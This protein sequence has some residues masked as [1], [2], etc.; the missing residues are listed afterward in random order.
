MHIS[1][2]VKKI[3]LGKRSGIYGYYSGSLRARC[4]KYVAWLEIP[5]TIIVAVQYLKSSNYRIHNNIKRVQTK[6]ML[7]PKNLIQ[8]NR[9]FYFA[10]DINPAFNSEEPVSYYPNHKRFWLL[11]PKR[12]HYHRISI[13]SKCV[14]GSQK[15]SCFLM[16][17]QIYFQINI[18]DVFYCTSKQAGSLLLNKP[19]TLIP[20]QKLVCISKTSLFQ[21]LQ[22]RWIKVFKRKQSKF[23]CVRKLVAILK[24]L[25]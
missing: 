23:T 5:M 13:F 21:S 24:K 20:P 3:H 2:S 16:V 9:P 11:N 12:C 1:F 4:N 19:F 15:M 14:V 7:L 18:T 22:I 10:R 8:G 6:S 25:D 17:R